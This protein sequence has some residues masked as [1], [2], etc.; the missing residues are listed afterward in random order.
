MVVRSRGAW[1]DLQGSSACW[2]QVLCR[3]LLLPL[4][5]WGQLQAERWLRI[6][7][8]KML[9]PWDLGKP[10]RPDLGARKPL[11]SGTRAAQKCISQWITTSQ[12]SCWVRNNDSPHSAPFFSGAWRLIAHNYCFG[13]ANLYCAHGRQCPSW[14][15]AKPDIMQEELRGAACC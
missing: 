7:P 5:S 3:L 13:R 12:S 10:S 1:T 11:C 8:C 15:A 9:L 2:T 6:F 14:L 4:P